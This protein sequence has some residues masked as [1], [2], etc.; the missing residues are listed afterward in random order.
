M[1][2]ALLKETYQARKKTLLVLLALFLVNLVLYLFVALYQNPRVSG[3]RRQAAEKAQLAAGGVT[4]DA[5]AIYRQGKSDLAAWREKIAP[6]KEFTRLVG[7]LFELAA[8]NSLKVGGVSYKPAVI[9]EEN[10]LAYSIDF[11]VSGKYA[12]IKSFIADLARQRNIMYIDN[13]ALN[14]QKLTEESINMKLQL[15]AFFRMEGQ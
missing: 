4:Q 10:L 14:N 12:A 6:K 15:T 9:K 8:G 11:N 1:N 13:L 3:L 7:E 5:A 2:I